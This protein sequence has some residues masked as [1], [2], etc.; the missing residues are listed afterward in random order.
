M[1]TAV[2]QWAHFGSFWVMMMYVAQS[3]HT[4]QFGDLGTDV[5]MM[6][7]AEWVHTGQSRFSWLAH[8]RHPPERQMAMHCKVGKCLN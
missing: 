3:A 6:C 8:H 1:M 2:A 7:V 4:G 5:M